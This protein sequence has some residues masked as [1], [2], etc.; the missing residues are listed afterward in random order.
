MTLL[1]EGSV[2]VR[3][4]GSTHLTMLHADAGVKDVKVIGMQQVSVKTLIIS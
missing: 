1:S 2:M 3:F 4:D